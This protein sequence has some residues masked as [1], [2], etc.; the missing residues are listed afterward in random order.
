MRKATKAATDAAKAAQAANTDAENRFREDERPYI[1]FTAAGNGTPEFH[2]TPNTNPP[3]GQVV[4]SWHYTDYGK[5]P[6]YGLQ[7][8]R[9]EIKVGDRPFKIMFERAYRPGIGT[10][11][12]PGKDDFA[13]IPSSP[14]AQ[15]DFN[16][17]L[18]ID[19]S[20]A[21]RGRVDYADAGGA[22]YETGFCQSRLTSGATEYCEEDNYIKA[23]SKPIPSS[24]DTPRP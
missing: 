19:R 6:A 15:E 9:E 18:Q 8:I 10:V 4:W 3:T 20:I 21:I 2:P 13:T 22:L 24:P 1:W 16:R 12:P 14:I 5:T 7:F 23:L 17:L 11:I